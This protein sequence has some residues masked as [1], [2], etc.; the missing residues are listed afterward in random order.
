[1]GKERQMICLSLSRKK[2]DP[3]LLSRLARAK[4]P[5]CVYTTRK[6]AREHL[7]QPS[8][9]QDE[10]IESEKDEGICPKL[11]SHLVTELGEKLMSPIFIETSSFSKYYCIFYFILS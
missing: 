1:M 7:V 3:A 4:G 11:C 2:L 9:F 6:H 10:D 8:Q 5:S